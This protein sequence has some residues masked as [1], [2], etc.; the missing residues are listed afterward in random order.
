MAQMLK[1]TQFI[2]LL[3]DLVNKMFKKY[4]KTLAK[5]DFK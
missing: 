2:Y 1:Q 3:K 5:Q 4:I